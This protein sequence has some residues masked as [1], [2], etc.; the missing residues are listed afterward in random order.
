MTGDW[1]NTIALYT[2]TERLTSSPFAMGL[3]FVIKMAA[4][5]LA[6]PIAG[7]V[8]DRF[9]RR[10]LMIG[11]DLIRAVIVL[12]FLFIEEASA[13]PLM[14]TLIFAQL[15][16]GA[17]FWPAKRASIPNICEPHELMTANAIS[18]A[19][20]SMMLAL[21]AGLGGL[22]AST[23]G[24]DAVFYIDAGTYL[25]SAW[26]ISRARIPQTFE[27]RTAETGPK[28][29]IVGQAVQDIAA[30][31]RYMLEHRHVGRIAL[32]K[33]AW[34]LGGGGA[35]FMLTQLG[36]HVVPTDFPLGIGLLYA[37]RGIGTGIGPIAARRFLVDRTRWP[38]I[39]GAFMIASGVAYGAAALVPWTL[40]FTIPVV[41]TA[42]AFA[43]ANWVLSTVILQ[44]HS[45][46]TFRGRV[47]A[48]EFLML[49]GVE[50]LSILAASLLLQAEV[51][52]LGTTLGV[53]GALMVASGVIWLWRPVTMP[54][55]PPAASR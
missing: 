1:F 38:T 15:A 55:R 40:A 24:L 35:V 34:V 9:D 29:S 2:L 48:T 10:R 26:F 13:L 16:V 19:T 23:L 8:A 36:E 27:A 50:S 33:T 6:S 21:G 4:L 28:R 51:L 45:E 49:A 46:D 32:A 31:W 25:V 44:E 42:H 11:S 12:G 14:Y 41:I 39:L 30:G 52:T 47:F 5:A 3:V 18:S 37:A 22:A 43:G 17:V 54:S 53:F 7:L 20:W